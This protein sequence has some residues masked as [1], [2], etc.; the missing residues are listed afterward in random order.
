[1]KKE[2]LILGIESSCDETAVSVVRNGK[3]MLS[4]VV[5]SQIESH[6]RFGG[7]VPEIASRHHVE[8]ITIVLEEALEQAGVTMADI[9]AIAVTEGPGLVGAL[10]IGVNAAKTLAFIHNKPLIGVHHIAGHIYANRFETE[11]QFPLLSLVVSGGHTELVVMREHGRFD[12]IGETRDDAAGEAYDKVARTLG[13]TY[14][15]GVQ[16]DKLAATGEDSFHFPRAMMDEASYDFSFS[17]LKSSFIN[18][19]HNLRQK[20]MALNEADLAASFQASVVD[21]LVAKTIRAA[22]EYDVKQLLLAGGVAANHGLRERLTEQVASE[23]PDV[24]L[25]IPPLSLCG[26]NAAMIAA[27]GT[28]MYEQGVFS[29]LAMNANPGLLFEDTYGV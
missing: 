28:I 10:L 14:P 29:D 6:K 19:V 18:T 21:V 5:A 16:I 26:D 27:A 4:N 1:M 13:L 3:E 22:K 17:G 11:M 8:Q 20:E 12:I 2:T 23:L 24:T 15:G 9:D 7:V 25:I